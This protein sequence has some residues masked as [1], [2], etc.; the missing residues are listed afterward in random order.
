MLN[1]V[2]KDAVTVNGRTYAW[3]RRPSIVICFD[4]CDPA[5]ID[6]AE[7]AGNAP[8]LIGMKTNGFYAIAD[9]AMPSFTNP[10][11]VSIVTGAPPSIHGVSG[12]FY[13]DPVTGAPVMMVDAAP[14]RAPTI[15]AAFSEA[16]AR[17]AAITAKDKLRKA[18][19]AGL[20]GIAF[21]AELA[22]ETTVEEHGIADVAALVGTPLPDRYSAALSLFVLD[23][24]VRLLQ[25]ER[26]DLLYLSLSDYVQ[27]AH[28]PGTPEADRFMAAVDDRVGRFL[29]HGALVGIVADHGMSDM[30]H[31]D[32]RPNVLFLGDR[33]DEAFGV[34]ALTVVCPI[35][36]PFVRHHG[37][38]GGFVR[39]HGTPGVNLE[40]VR[41]FIAALPGVHLSLTRDEACARFDLPPDREGDLAVVAERGVAL[42]ARAREHDVSAL[43]GTR[44]RSHGGLCERA[45]PFL[46][47]EP[48]A[49]PFA[50]R[51]QTRLTNAD[52]FDFVLNGVLR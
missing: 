5:Y 34:G 18:L 8:N 12:N 38:L 10:N 36:D 26:F 27:H 14:L 31:P 30:S 15:L 51:A 9:A 16:G 32:G 11:N 41:T 48:V 42:G 13:L 1:A 4:G 29:A 22:H 3:P 40:V 39:V 37:A 24:G 47:S 7:V 20:R 44:L 50:A 46:I 23:A 2:G 19:G 45:I 21:S 6:A 43:A 17:V 25:R 49:A 28:A 35:T 52:I 33:L